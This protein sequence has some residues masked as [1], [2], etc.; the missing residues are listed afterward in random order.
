MCKEREVIVNIH[1]KMWK[2]N[3]ACLLAT[4]SS[5]RTEPK[6]KIKDYQSVQIQL[7][8]SDDQNRVMVNLRY[9]KT[10]CN[11]RRSV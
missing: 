3:V 4:S 5:V 1:G 7:P 8:S 9:L 6:S 2:C 11:C 10:K